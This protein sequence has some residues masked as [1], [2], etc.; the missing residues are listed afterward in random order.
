[1]S[2]SAAYK[3]L[4]A[5]AVANEDH[6]ASPTEHQ[7]HTARGVQRDWHRAAFALPARV[8]RVEPLLPMAGGERYSHRA[9]DR[10]EV[11]EHAY[12]V[13]LSPTPQEQQAVHLLRDDREPV[14]AQLRQRWLLA[15]QAEQ[16]A[17]EVVQHAVLSLVAQGVLQAGGSE[18]RLVLRIGH[19]GGV[20]KRGELGA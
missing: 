8:G 6:G 13:G 20:V 3:L 9:L 7:I 17:V 14:A 19:G 12:L 11:Q 10:A 16:L 2:M 1:M 18:G 15:T 5:P 4:G